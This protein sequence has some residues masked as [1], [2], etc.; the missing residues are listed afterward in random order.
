MAWQR[1]E[2]CAVRLP[3]DRTVFYKMVGEVTI[4]NARVLSYCP[5]LLPLIQCVY[6]TD[7]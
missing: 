3:A 4:Q 2:L 1:I 5:H 6:G 7:G